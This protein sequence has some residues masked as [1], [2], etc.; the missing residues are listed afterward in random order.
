FREY[1]DGDGKP[2]Q[3]IKLGEE[4]QVHIKLRAL[5]DAP[6]DQIAVVDLLPGGFEPVVQVKAKAE[7]PPVEEGAG[8]EGGEGAE[9][10]GHEEGEGGEGEGTTSFALPIAL[11]G[12]TF[13]ASYGDVREDRVVLYGAALPQVKELVYA[14]RATN[15]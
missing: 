2:I 5:G 15:T 6:I 12:S 10:E 9:G 1:T 3:T 11:A 7:A 14:A 13:E 8:G 4:M